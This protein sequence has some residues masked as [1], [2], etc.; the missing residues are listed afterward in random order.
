M[1]KK[2][3]KC[4]KEKPK[5]ADFFFRDGKRFRSWCKDCC[6]IHR[7]YNPLVYSKVNKKSH[8]KTKLL[9][10]NHY[11]M[12]CA[13]CRENHFEFLTIDHIKGGGTEHRRQPKSKGGAG[14]YSWLKQNNFP[15][16]FQTLCCNCNFSLGRY[17]YCP[18]RPEIRREVKKG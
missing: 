1:F 4:Q 14:F 18:H 8:L 9:V 3:S 15:E 11:G 17:G 6:R 12:F 10:F 2:C 5:T 7:K 13:C 16:G